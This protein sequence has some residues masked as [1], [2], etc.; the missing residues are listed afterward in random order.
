MIFSLSCDLDALNELL[1][2]DVVTYSTKTCP[3]LRSLSVR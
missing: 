1:P 3:Y 2:L